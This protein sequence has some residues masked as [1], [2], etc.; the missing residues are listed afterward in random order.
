MAAPSAQ[1]INANPGPGRNILR[2]LGLE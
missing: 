1:P 2:E